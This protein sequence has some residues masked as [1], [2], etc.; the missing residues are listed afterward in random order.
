[1]LPRV[2]QEVIT[3]EA[4]VLQVPC[5]MMAEPAGPADAVGCMGPGR[6]MVGGRGMAGSI[7]ELPGGCCVTQGK[8]DLH[9][10]A[11]QPSHACCSGAAGSW[12][13]PASRAAR[14]AIRQPEPNTLDAVAAVPCAQGLCMAAGVPLPGP[15]GRQP[16][17]WL[18]GDAGLPEPRPAVPRAAERAARFCRQLHQ[19]TTTQAGSRAGVPPWRWCVRAAWLHAAALSSGQAT[20]WCQD[21]GLR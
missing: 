7:R 10:A 3:G 17:G 6:W 13:C 8:L 19:H 2:E 21:P 14:Q 11:P 12:R 5:G 20:L 1:M 15:Q 16:G 4:D 18:Q 9:R